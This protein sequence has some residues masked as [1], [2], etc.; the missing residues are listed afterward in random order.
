MVDGRHP[1]EG[2]GEGRPARRRRRPSRAATCATT[3]AR[4]S[5]PRRRRPRALPSSRSATPSVPGTRRRAS[6][7]AQKIAEAL[8]KAELRFDVNAGPQGHALR[9]GDGDRHRRRDLGE[10][11]DPRRP[12]EDRPARPDQ[13]HRPLR[14]PRRDL[15]RRDR[16]GA[17]AGRPRGRRASARGGARGEEAAEKAAE[18]AEAEAAAEQQAAVE[19]EVEQFVAEEEVPRRP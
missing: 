3:S 18:E 9:L 1:P 11:Q 19:A 17:D 2:R 13:A 8:G 10:A 16:R 4:G 15:H 5:S 6:S 12:A 14:D 7:D